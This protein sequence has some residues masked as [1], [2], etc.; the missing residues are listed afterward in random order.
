MVVNI[1]FTL[2]DETYTFFFFFGL[3]TK[4]NKKDTQNIHSVSSIDPVVAYTHI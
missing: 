2:I 4:V 3:D 1:V